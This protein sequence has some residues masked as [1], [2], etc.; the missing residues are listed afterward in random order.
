MINATIK[1]RGIQKLYE[2][3]K[4][5]AHF[6]IILPP[7]NYY[8]EISCHNYKSKLLYFVVTIDNL[9]SLNVVLELD[10]NVEM[11]TENK[12]TAIDSYASALTKIKGYIRDNMNHPITEAMIFIK[13][14]NITTFADKNGQY[15]AELEPGKYSIVVTAS[16]FIENVK[17]VDVTNI[18]NVPKY[19]MIT[20]NKDES[21]MGLPRMAFIIITGKLF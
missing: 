19:V 13:E 16:G 18:N 17:Y 12:E 14:A 20:L 6:K 8:V 11:V 2:V 3:T 15:F 9:T 7:G 1:V 21:V 10:D 5:N 4:I